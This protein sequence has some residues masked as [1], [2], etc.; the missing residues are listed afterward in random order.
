MT[1]ASAQT[2]KHGAGGAG[3][4]MAWRSPAHQ[5]PGPCSP[6]W[7]AQSLPPV[8]RGG[9]RCLRHGLGFKLPGAGLSTQPWMRGR[10][11]PWAVQPPRAPG[12][13]R[14]IRHDLPPATHTCTQHTAS[15]LMVSHMPTLQ[16]WP[17]WSWPKCRREPQHPLQKSS[18]PI[19]DGPYGEGRLREE[20]LR[21]GCAAPVGK[22]L[23]QE[24]GSQAGV[25]AA[26]GPSGNP[27]SSAT[28]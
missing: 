21:R 2:R 24:A 15:V 22:E 13:R 4:H 5:E 23:C 8:Q 17:C 3:G 19:P 6:A 12:H 16:S 28:S 11:L 27:T 14:N 7:W 20:R 26:S 18:H 1:G 9:R 10:L 25:K